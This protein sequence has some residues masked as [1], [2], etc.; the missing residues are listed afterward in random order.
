MTQSHALRDIQKT[1]ARE[2]ILNMAL[3]AIK[4][5]EEFCDRV[6]RTINVI[7]QESLDCLTV[8][9]S[10]LTEIPTMMKD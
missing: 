10:Y 4:S 9:V 2:T 7:S 3:L 5:Y 6:K 8:D 1:A